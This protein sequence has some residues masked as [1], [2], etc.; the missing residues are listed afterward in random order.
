MAV[1][2]L[3][4]ML[5]AYQGYHQVPS[6]RDDQE[7][8]NF[9]TEDG[10]YCYNMM[11]FGL[12]NADIEETFGTLRT[13]RVKIN[14][15]KCLFGVKSGCFLGYI[16]TERGIEANPSKV[17]VLQ[18]MPAAS[19]ESEGGSTPYG[20]NN[21]AVQIHLED[22]RPEFALFQDSAPTKPVAGEALR[23]YLSSTEYVVES[24]LVRPDGEEQPMYFLSHILKDAE[25]HYTGLEKLAFALPRTTIKEQSLAD[26][27]TEVQE[28]EPEATW[29]VYVD[30]S[31]TRQG[32]GIGVLLISPHGERMHLSVRLDYRATNNEVE[33]EALIVG[34]Q[35]ARH[36]GA[37]KVLIHSDSQLAAQQLSGAFE[38]RSVRL[39]FYAEAF[40]KLK[41]QVADELAKLASSISPI[42]I[43]QPIERVSLVAHIDRMEGLTFPNDW[44][45][46]I[47]EFLKSG[48]TPPDRLEVHLLRRR[49]CRFVLIGDQLYKKAFSRPLLK[50]V[51]PEDVDYILQE[52]HQGSCGGHSGG[53]SLARKILLDGYFWPTLQADAAWTV[54]TCLSYQKYHN[55]SHRPV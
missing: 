30:G 54:A 19:Q 5:D 6:A 25:S 16:V 28:P 31:S 23:V 51:G 20:T 11:S 53:H 34:L 55:S 52:V 3:I 47:T 36:V 12:K 42:V 26:F 13:Y 32:S 24:D 40:E 10:S 37:S 35:V 27:V 38:I 2:E 21:R 43:Q 18:D 46:T 1:C 41:N 9:I 8:V 50:C 45:T 44:R 39:K 7:K 17:K 29:Q 22:H 4:C 49:A 15:Q 48:A 33:Y 14:P